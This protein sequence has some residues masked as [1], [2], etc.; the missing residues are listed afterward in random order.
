MKTKKSIWSIALSLIVILALVLSFGLSSQESAVRAEEEN[1]DHITF[2][3]TV[4]GLREKSIESTH[5]NLLE[6]K[7][8]VTENTGVDAMQ[9]RIDFSSAFTLERIEALKTTSLGE[10]TINNGTAVEPLNGENY[11]AYNDI[12]LE[13]ENHN[14]IGAN[15]VYEHVNNRYTE[16]GDVLIIAYYRLN[17]NPTEEVYPFGFWKANNEE[18]FSTA[19]K[20]VANAEQS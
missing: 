14:Y 2:N 8:T 11:V 18:G 9:L 19:W 10:P 1:T 3:I 15:I 7:Y 6:V 20:N 13:D 4:D 16:T 5:S 12:I 17:A